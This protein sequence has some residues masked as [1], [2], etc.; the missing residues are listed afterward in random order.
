M[1]QKIMLL[2]QVYQDNLVMIVVDEADCIARW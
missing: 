2:S 1:E